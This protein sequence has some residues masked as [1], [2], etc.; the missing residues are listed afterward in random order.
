MP[1]TTIFVTVLTIYVV[2]FWEFVQN[3]KQDKL[4]HTVTY[5]K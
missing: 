4:K 5:F 2:T 1:T 3:Y